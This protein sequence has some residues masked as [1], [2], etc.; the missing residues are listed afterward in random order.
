MQTRSSHITKSVL[1]EMVPMF[2]RGLTLFLLLALILSTD[3]L[4]AQ[5]EDEIIEEETEE[6]ENEEVEDEE[7]SIEEDSEESIEEI[8][9]RRPEEQPEEAGPAEAEHSRCVL[10]LFPFTSSYAEHVYVSNAVSKH[11]AELDGSYIV[12]Q[13]EFD[14][15]NSSQEELQRRFESLKP[16]FDSGSVAAVIG[17]GQEL[18]PLLDRNAG[19]IPEKTALLLFSERMPLKTEFAGHENIGGVFLDNPVEK[20]IDLIFQV[21]PGTKRIIPLAGR[22]ETGERFIAGVKEAL[23]EI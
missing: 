19:L 6:V 4:Y 11:I 21:F 15:L 1:F 13:K 7:E 14:M 23:K 2:R 8:S 16:L 9:D 10:M 5:E 18:L 20:S 3:P 22:T 12:M 17:I